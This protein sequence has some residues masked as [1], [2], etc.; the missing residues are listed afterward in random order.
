MET[1]KI[2]AQKDLSASESP[3][4]RLKGCTNE[5]R[6]L[7]QELLWNVT[8]A[9]HPFRLEEEETPLAARKLTKPLPRPLTVTSY[10]ALAPGHDADGG[11]YFSRDDDEPGSDPGETLSLLPSVPPERLKGKLFGLL[12][13]G[14]MENLDF[15]ADAGEIRKIVQREMPFPDP[16]EEELDHTVS[17]ISKT[18]ALPIF[19]GV[20]LADI[21]PEKRK[22]EMRFHFSFHNALDREKLLRL[23]V[24]KVPADS[25]D[26]DGFPDG[27][28]VTGS[29]DLVFEHGG[30]YFVLDW[31]SNLLPD[32]SRE[33]LDRSMAEN[34][35]RLQYMIYLAAF[36]RYLRNRLRLPAFG[37]EEY[38]KYIGGVFYI[39]MRG[40]DP[41]VPG[42]GVF[43]DRPAFSD[44][45]KV[46]EV[47]E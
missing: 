32:Y 31:K 6:Q 43:F 20:L 14:I 8:P 24:G 29:I 16:S 22:A 9:D 11:L 46:Q 30:K 28:Y 35:Y 21:P 2:F 10:T 38:E 7:P 47:F 17:V 19:P 33:S 5:L 41:A 3:S 15:H 45:A 42:S 34:F 26:P 37:E 1:G 40:A 44:V 25:G 13:H 36:T 4:V 12:L 18:L 23:A 39:Y 27:G